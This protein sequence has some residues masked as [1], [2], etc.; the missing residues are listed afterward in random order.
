VKSTVDA[1]T[2]APAIA[3]GP[4]F[5]A[6]NKGRACLGRWRVAEGTLGCGPLRGGSR[7]D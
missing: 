6:I 1:W 4:V 7:Q 5:R 2:A 3:H